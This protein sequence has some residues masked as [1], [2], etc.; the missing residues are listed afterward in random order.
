MINNFFKNQSDITT[1]IS[2]TKTVLAELEKSLN[3]AYEKLDKMQDMI[4]CHVIAN[5]NDQN[6]KYN[7]AQLTK[8]MRAIEAC[9]LSMKQSTII[10]STTKKM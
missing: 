9:R 6:A 3:V 1:T 8:F 2:D 10:D 5:P 7:L 4:L